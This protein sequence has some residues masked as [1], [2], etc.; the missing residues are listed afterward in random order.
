MNSSAYTAL[1]PNW[2]IHMDTAVHSVDAK[3]P[4]FRQFAFGLQ[5][6]LIMYTGCV[7]VPLVFGAAVGLDRDTIAMLIS[8]DLLIAGSSPS[9]RALAS[10]SSSGFGCPSSAAPPSRG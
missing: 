7:T 10:A 2:S 3:L 8:A 4:F 5:H 1:Y 9:F 6:V